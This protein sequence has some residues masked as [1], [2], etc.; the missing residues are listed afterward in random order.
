M[1]WQVLWRVLE[2]SFVW[3]HSPVAFGLLIVESESSYVLDSFGFA[4]AIA[5]TT[6]TSLQPP[7][8][9][10]M[11]IEITSWYDVYDVYD[12]YIVYIVCS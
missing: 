6:K 8:V 12:V 10:L 2:P 5:Q 7:H 11:V 9:S 1:P 4:I 3:K